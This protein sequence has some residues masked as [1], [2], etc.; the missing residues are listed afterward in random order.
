[1]GIEQKIRSLHC[2][3]QA[4]LNFHDLNGEA[5]IFL[6][7]VPFEWENIIATWITSR[8]AEQITEGVPD[9]ILR[10]HPEKG[11]ALTAEGWS[12]YVSWMTE[13]LT[14]AQEKEHDCSE[15]T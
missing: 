1:M 10:R 8:R 7:D 13:A 6:R 12:G 15:R 14:A 11:L 5:V 2:G 9:C 4:G 3:M